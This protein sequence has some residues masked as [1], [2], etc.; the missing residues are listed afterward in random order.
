MDIA[1]PEEQ[2]E[3]ASTLPHKDV[4][5]S[6]RFKKSSNPDLPL[7][8]QQREILIEFSDDKKDK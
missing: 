8:S 6:L 5:P 1:N 2:Y 4:N 7:E 3:Y